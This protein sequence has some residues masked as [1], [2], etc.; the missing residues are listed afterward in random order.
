MS[1]MWA[2]ALLANVRIALEDGTVYEFELR[3]DDIGELVVEVDINRPPREL[4]PEETNYSPWREYV[5]GPK[6]FGEIKLKGLVGSMT[7]TKNETEAA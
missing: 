3:P 7:R 2:K 4:S 1:A 6:T 5:S